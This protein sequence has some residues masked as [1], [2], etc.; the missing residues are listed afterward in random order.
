VDVR[1]G[2]ALQAT[3]VYFDPV[4]DLAVL[5]VPGLNLRPLPLSPTVSAGTH[6]VS[7]GYPFGGPFVSLSV[8]VQQVGTINVQN[9]YGTGDSP[10]EVYSLAADIQEGDSGGPMLT[11]A[12]KVAGVVFAK[13]ATTPDVGYAITMKSVA[14]VAARAHL[15]NTAV[16]SGRCTRG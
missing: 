12:G 7:D 10:R 13:G 11:T 8:G 14:P 16:S 9:I 1:G 5:E 15:L 3:V 2:P 6:A 4:G